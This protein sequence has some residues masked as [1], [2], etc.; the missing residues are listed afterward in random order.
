MS[1]L[2]QGR[3][4]PAGRHP[5]NAARLPAPAAMSN[6]SVHGSAMRF[7]SQL[8]AAQG[9]GPAPSQRGQS[10]L[11]LWWR[12][13]GAS[14]RCLGFRPGRRASAPAGAIG[15]CRQVRAALLS[16]PSPRRGERRG[17]RMLQL[18]LG[19]LAGGW[20]G[21][22]LAGHGVPGGAGWAELR[23]GRG[24]ADKALRVSLARAYNI[25]SRN[26][27]A[28]RIVPVEAGIWGGSPD[29]VVGLVERRWPPV[30]CGRPGRCRAG[31]QNLRAYVSR[32]VSRTRIRWRR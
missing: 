14:A 19:G 27:I 4:V 2:A 32:L 16:T 3:P 24:G 11:A 21:P 25:L 15:P 18:R 29:R 5:I 22:V 30:E 1:G 12:W 26:E 13:P 31:L 10:P 6:P 20:R 8:M 9:G 28:A 17:C 23:A 7:P